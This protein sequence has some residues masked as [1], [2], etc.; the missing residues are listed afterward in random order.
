[1]RFQKI[2]TLLILPLILGSC[3]NKEPFI[4]IMQNPHI[5]VS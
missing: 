4:S 2:L 5:D 1:M 3:D